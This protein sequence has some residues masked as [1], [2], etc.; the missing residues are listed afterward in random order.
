MSA[1]LTLAGKELRDGLRNRWIAAAILL[2]AGLALLLSVL[3]AAPGGGVKAGALSVTVASLA[4][5]TVYLLPLI[6]LML[7][8]DA[9]V[10]EAER[11]TLLLLLAYPVPRWA[12]VLGKFTGHLGI[13]ALALLVGYGGTGLLVAAL[14][15]T[16]PEDWAALA[17]LLASSL[18]LGAI[19]LAAGYLISTLVRE[20]ATA[21]GIAMGLWLLLVALYDLGLLALLIADEGQV[22]GQGLFA[23]LLL[24]NPTDAFR[25][26]NLAGQESAAL[27]VGLA[28]A[29]GATGPGALQALGAMLAWLVLPLAATV[30]LFQ[31]REL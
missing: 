5:L 22:I 1:L 28:A 20:R 19:F 13:L 21:V 23:A 15:E 6:A 7:A 11:G 25:L 4:S 18:L 16:K 24:A 2:L 30:W 27:A 12:F 8:Y 9:V 17:T 29:K 10:G 26:F 14:N 3:G 31:R